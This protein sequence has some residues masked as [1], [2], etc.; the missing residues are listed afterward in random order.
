MDRIFR[1]SLDAGTTSYAF[2]MIWILAHIHIHFACF[3]ALTTSD[4]FVVLNLNVK[5]ADL[6]K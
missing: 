6:I 3:R 2:R 4:T 1:A 5:K